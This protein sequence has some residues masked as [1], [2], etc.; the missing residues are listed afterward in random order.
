[1]LVTHAAGGGPILVHD[2]ALL[3]A[4]VLQR[5][6]FPISGHGD[7]SWYIIF[8]GHMQSFL[9]GSYL[10]VEVPGHRVGVFSVVAGTIQQV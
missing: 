7:Y 6:V 3:Y 9:M 5:M 2:Y 1:M 8:C 10:G 4:P